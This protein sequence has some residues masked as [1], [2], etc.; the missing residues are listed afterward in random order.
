MALGAILRHSWC[1]F[2]YS[3]FSR[4]AG[5]VHGTAL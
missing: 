1:D 4:V 2:G 3:P 5:P